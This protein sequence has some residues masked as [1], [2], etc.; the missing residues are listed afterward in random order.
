MIKIME[1][2]S[3]KKISKTK[4]IKNNKNSTTAKL[5]QQ[6]SIKRIMLN[7]DI[8]TKLKIIRTQWTYQE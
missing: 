8:K 1:K 2:H 3:I 5:F 7:K 4:K 6:I